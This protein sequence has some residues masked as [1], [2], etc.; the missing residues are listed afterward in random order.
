MATCHVKHTSRKIFY[1]HVL[2][3]ISDNCSFKMNVAIETQTFQSTDFLKYI[4]SI[5]R[6]NIISLIMNLLVEL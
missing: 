1:V 5:D 6:V 3:W 4:Y 2:N